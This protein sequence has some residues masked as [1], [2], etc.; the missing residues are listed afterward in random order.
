MLAAV[1]ALHSGQPRAVRVTIEQQRAKLDLCESVCIVHMDI[2][3]HKK[4]SGI[5]SS[6]DKLI[7]VSTCIDS[8]LEKIKSLR[9]HL[10]RYD[11]I[12]AELESGKHVD[13]AGKLLSMLA[14]QESFIDGLADSI[15]A[16]DDM[17]TGL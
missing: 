8:H 2:L 6:Q 17:L 10:S 5:N 12:C 11:I 9:G 13:Q 15:K 4:L 1:V 3:R 14:M 7:S 16:Q